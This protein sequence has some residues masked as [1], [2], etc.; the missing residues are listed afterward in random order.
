MTIT[1][2]QYAKLGVW[3]LSKLSRPIN[4][5][6]G[7]APC[8]LWTDW[9][10]AHPVAPFCHHP[11]QQH[12]FRALRKGMGRPGPQGSDRLCH[13]VRVDAPLR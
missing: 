4:V 10:A 6:D 9:I 8:P 12:V 2:I 1:F 7:S 3:V 13:R 11:P 5:A